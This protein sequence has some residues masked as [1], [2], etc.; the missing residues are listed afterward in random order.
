MSQFAANPIKWEQDVG[1]GRGLREFFYDPIEKTLF[2]EPEGVNSTDVS[3]MSPHKRGGHATEI[4]GMLSIDAQSTGE[5]AKFWKATRPFREH[6]DVGGVGVPDSVPSEN[7]SEPPPQEDVIPPPTINPPTEQEGQFLMGNTQ[8]T[9]E[10]ESP[11]IGMDIDE[12]TR[13]KYAP[14]IEMQAL[15][16]DIYEELIKTR[17]APDDE[18]HGMVEMLREKV[19]KLRE[20]YYDDRRTQT[21]DEGAGE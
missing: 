4:P 17:L 20:T 15:V 7:G 9:S 19:T 11:I 1:D 6:Y 16:I 21:D 2:I 13:Q 14:L 12:Y 10:P 5:G 18:S 8:S 3:Q